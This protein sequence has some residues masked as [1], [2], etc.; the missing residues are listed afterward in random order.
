MKNTDT[1]GTLAQTDEDPIEQIFKE[2][3]M[4]CDEAIIRR[5]G[6]RMILE[7]NKRSERVTE[8][9]GALSN[10]PAAGKALFPFDIRF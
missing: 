9:L 8:N 2:F 4:D 6:K 7:P 10:M 1:H 3:E 5:E